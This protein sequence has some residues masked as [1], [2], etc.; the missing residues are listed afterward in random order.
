M[1]L[2][3]L[4][5]KA[6]ANSRFSNSGFHHISIKVKDFDRSFHFYTEVLGFGVALNW[7]DKPKRACMLDIG[8]G[9]Y[10]ELFEGG[11]SQV[12]IQPEPMIHFALSTDD[13]DGMYKA[14]MDAGCRSQME[15]ENLVINGKERDLEIRISFVVGYDGEVIEFFQCR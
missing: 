8:D 10:V 1:L 2:E 7:G 4:L 5:M 9:S 3:W 13:C 12:D 6:I 11:N 14:A 15:P